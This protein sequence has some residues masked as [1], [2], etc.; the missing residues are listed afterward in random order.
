V[1]LN[2]ECLELNKTYC[3]LRVFEM[4]KR[5]LLGVLC[6]FLLALMASAVIPP[7]TSEEYVSEC[8]SIDCEINTNSTTTAPPTATDNEDVPP[9]GLVIGGSGNSSNQ[10]FLLWGIMAVVVIALTIINL[11]TGL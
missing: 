8:D 7:D 4:E 10:I 9:T 1:F 6:C 5:G 2:E 3:Y 11:K